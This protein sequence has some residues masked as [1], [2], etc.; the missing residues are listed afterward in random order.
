LEKFEEKK[1][2]ERKIEEPL[3]RQTPNVRAFLVQKQQKFGGVHKA[4]G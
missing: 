3:R 1:R 2:A 4:K